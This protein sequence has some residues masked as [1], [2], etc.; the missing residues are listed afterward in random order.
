MPVSLF[1]NIHLKFID[2]D[3]DGAM[4]ISLYVL[5]YWQIGQARIVYLDKYLIENKH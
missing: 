4:K 5:F 2:L 1:E 3:G